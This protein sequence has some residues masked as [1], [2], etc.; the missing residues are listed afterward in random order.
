MSTLELAGAVSLI[1]LCAVVAVIL[2][3]PGLRWLLALLYG[4][5]KERPNPD[6]CYLNL[7]APRITLNR[8]SCIY[9]ERYAHRL[10]MQGGWFWFASI[11][12]A[13]RFTFRKVHYCQRCFPVPTQSVALSHYTEDERRIER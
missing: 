11:E 8:P 10:K 12:E 3:W 4:R 6:E 9:V 5:S 2:T 7:D 13:K 1:A